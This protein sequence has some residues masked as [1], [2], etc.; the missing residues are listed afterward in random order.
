VQDYSRFLPVAK[1]HT[2]CVV[3]LRC[4]ALRV[5]VRD[6]PLLRRQ[7]EPSRLEVLQDLPRRS[8]NHDGVGLGVLC[9]A[10]ARGWRAGVSRRTKQA[11]HMMHSLMH[12]KRLD[13]QPQVN[14][15]SPQAT[16]LVFK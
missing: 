10:A 4:V 16:T 7:H 9:V 1:A 12:K 13:V 5:S 14:M 2:S 11:P 6:S 3:A 8:R 15:C